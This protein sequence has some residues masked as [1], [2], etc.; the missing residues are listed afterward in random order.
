MPF[1]LSKEQEEKYL[2]DFKEPF[3]IRFWDK[4]TKTFLT[5]NLKNEKENERFNDLVKYPLRCKIEITQRI[6]PTEDFKFCYRHLARFSYPMAVDDDDHPTDVLK[7]QVR[8]GVKQI[9]TILEQAGVSKDFLSFSHEE[10]EQDITFEVD[11]KSKTK[12]Y[13]M[14]SLNFFD[15]SS[16]ESDDDKKFKKPKRPQS[17]DVLSDNPKR[18]KLENN[19]VKNETFEIYTQEIL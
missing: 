17:E 2:K 4:K 5:S 9:R 1:T 6:P 19:Q 12:T 11:E 13:L 16:D 15:T 18:S 8:Q 7:N 10:K 3:G 14:D